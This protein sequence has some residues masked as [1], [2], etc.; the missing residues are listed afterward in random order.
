MFR[1]LGQISILN[2]ILNIDDKQSLKIFLFWLLK[3]IY[4]VGFVVGWTA[5]MAMFVA[6]YGIKSLPYLF[7]LNGIFTII[8]TVLYSSVI[9]RI[10]KN[11]CLILTIFAS[12]GTLFL[13]YLFRHSPF[14]FFAFLITAVSVFLSQFRIVLNLLIEDYFSPLESEKVFP[15]LE[16]SETVGGLVA[17]LVI[18]FFAAFIKTSTAF[19]YFW[20][21]LLV[22][23]VPII[24]IASVVLVPPEGHAVHVKKK[25]NPDLI[26]KF[27]TIFKEN[28]Y[29]DF[30][31]GLSLIVFLQWVLFNLVEFQYTKAVYQSASHVILEAGSG[32]EHAFFHELGILF[33]IFSASAFVIQLIIGSRLVY[34]LGVFGS[35]L[36]HP[37]LTILSLFGLLFSFNFTTAVLMRNN[38]TVT[39]VLYASSL[40]SSYYA[41]KED[42]RAYL[43]EFLEGILRPVGAIFGT[44]FLIVLQ[45]FFVGNSLI[46][47]MN[48]VMFAF[49]IILFFVVYRQQRLYTETASAQF[50]SNHE[51][52]KIDA[53]EI[54][55]QKGHN[56]NIGFLVS[57]LLD[58][59]QSVLTKKKIIFAL[60]ELQNISTVPDLVK[61]FGDKCEAIREAALDA[62]YRFRN[63]SDFALNVV[64]EYELISALEKFYK[65]EKNSNLRFKIINLLSML[66]NVEAADFLLKILKTSKGNFKAGVLY[67]LGNI[68]DSAICKFVVPYLKSADLR[69]K[70]SAAIAIGRFREFYDESKYIIDTFLHSQK[71]SEIALGIYAI[72][73]L[74]IRSRKKF[75]V[76][77]LDSKNS[78]LKLSAAIAL[79]KMGEDISIPVVVEALTSRNKS[80]SSA[81]KRNLGNI[82]VRISKNIDKIVTHINF[83]KK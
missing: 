67:S 78:D 26:L 70:I 59:T 66:S 10:K 36:I 38:F 68:K 56:G 75:C 50:D 82:D 83:N 73:E 51:K 16:S 9:H 33:I 64:I 14:L 28:K 43:R 42:A 23:I 13:A 65:S 6:K 41:M 54:L 72:G 35:M 3:S 45:N 8:G 34:S 22:L 7:I 1:N 49:A 30:V 5:T 69:Q 21:G 2:K 76:K 80:L 29:F 63:R 48:I 47:Y 37:I 20:A 17:G 15:I 58:S 19:I 24:M 71:N 81:A 77:Y 11:L 61:C 55:A 44:F 52:E 62:L 32:F 25:E 40:E 53:V 31:K 39:N 79:A 27:K 46:L 18:T 12:M 57:K 4:R 74:N 60:G